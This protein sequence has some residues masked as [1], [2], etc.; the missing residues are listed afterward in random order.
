VIRRATCLLLALA[1]LALVA[2]GCGSSKSTG[3]GLDTALGYV[4]KG[5]PLV[6]AI[7]TDSDGGQW[8]QVDKLIGRFPFGG[9]VKQQF[10]N[11]FNSRAG[12]DYD[13]DFKPL[14]GGDFVVA[15]TAASAPG[16]PTPYVVAWKVGD[17][18]AARRLAEKNGKKVDSIEGADTFQTTSGRLTAIKDGTLVSAGNTDA[19][20]AA[21]KRPA[22][23]HMSEQEFTDSLGDLEKDSLVRAVGNFQVL[24]SG[25]EAAAARK[26]K[27]LNALRT[28]GL[29]LRAEPDGIEYSFRAETAGG[30]RD[31]DLPLPP[32]AESAPVVRRAGEVGFGIRN[33]AQIWSFGQSVARITDPA[34]YAKFTREKAQLSK[35]L[36]VNVDRDLVG[37]LTGNAALSVGI[38][39]AFALRADLRDPAAAARTLR[40]AAP[41]L[42]QVGKKRGKSLGLSTPKGGQGFYALATPNGKKIVFGVVGKSFVLATDAARAAQFAGESPSTVPGAKGSLVIASDAR[43]LANAVA[44]QRGQGVAAQIVTAALGDLI[45]SVEAEPGGI[46][47]SLKLHI[48]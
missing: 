8:Q 44:K 27:F 29:T 39:G 24:L 35:Q 6:V 19:L 31:G 38:D 46:T 26:V 28:F 13:R 12:L 34:G 3:S 42:V 47:G 4:P 10:K 40:K 22:G 17:E 32:G 43:S 23:E 37:Q 18:D 16:D 14:L 25:P 15:I 1:A 30:L 5:A 36:G 7:D 9:Q 48:K 2:S 45:G 20:A 41:R 21:L 33:P 11:G